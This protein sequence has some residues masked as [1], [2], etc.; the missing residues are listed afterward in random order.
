MVSSVIDVKSLVLL[1]NI[2]VQNMPDEKPFISFLE[3]KIIANLYT[4]GYKTHIRLE[5]T[6]KKNSLARVVLKNGKFV[7]R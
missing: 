4:F 5:D 3:Q 1:R 7:I 6:S 2:F